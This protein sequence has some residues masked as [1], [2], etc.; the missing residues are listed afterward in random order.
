[1]A[2]KV[3]RSK[4]KLTTTRVVLLQDLIT[5]LPKEEQ[6]AIHTLAAKLLRKA[7]STEENRISRECKKTRFDHGG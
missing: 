1:M 6:N 5:A 7:K 3:T 2:K 4:K